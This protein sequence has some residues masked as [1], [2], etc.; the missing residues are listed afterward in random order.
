M[1]IATRLP[2]EDL[3]HILE[4]FRED[5]SDCIYGSWDYW[6]QKVSKDFPQVTECGFPNIMHELITARAQSIFSKYP[7]N[8]VFMWKQNHSLRLTIHQRLIIRFKKFRPGNKT[9]NYRTR[10]ADLF[11]NQMYIEEIG[12]I[13][14]VNVGY[15]PDQFRTS[16]EAYI[17]YPSGPRNI[18]DEPLPRIT[19]IASHPKPNEEMEER[20]ILP[21][22]PKDDKAKTDSGRNPIS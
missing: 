5:L 15:L 11:D 1:D 2:K 19:R 14:R 20:I 18:W 22:R 10:Q 12:S 9:S 8:V 7:Q 6:L 16:I 17:T 13:D 4:P 3:L 21:F